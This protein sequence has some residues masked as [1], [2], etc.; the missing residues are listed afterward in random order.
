MLSEHSR[1]IQRFD[2]CRTAFMLCRVPEK[3][4]SITPNFRDTVHV[5]NT[6]VAVHQLLGPERSVFVTTELSPQGVDHDDCRIQLPGDAIV[7]ENVQ[8]SMLVPEVRLCIFGDDE[9]GVPPVQQ[10]I[11]WGH[12]THGCILHTADE[13]LTHGV[14]VAVLVDGCASHVKDM[15]DT[16]VL[17]MSR[18]DG[19]MITTAP[20]AVMQLTRSDARF[21]K[22]I[23]KI[24]KTFGAN[25]AATQLQPNVAA[26]HS[27]EGDRDRAA[28]ADNAVAAPSASAATAAAV[29]ASCTT[30]A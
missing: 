11:I 27:A 1:L 6:M 2:T 20:S 4:Q 7:A 8:V 12:E 22:E 10:V 18:W 14:R 13:L 17:Q 25:W 16:A 3:V 21:V 5:T 30:S 24:L 26:P 9:R 29:A 15:H 23:V 28:A 19:L